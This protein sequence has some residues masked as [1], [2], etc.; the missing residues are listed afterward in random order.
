MVS[1]FR[2]WVEI[3][4][5][6][7]Y[8]LSWGLNIMNSIHCGF[9]VVHIWW[10]PFMGLFNDSWVL[11]FVWVGINSRIIIRDEWWLAVEL[12]KHV[13]FYSGLVSWMY[14]RPRVY[15]R[16]R[17]RTWYCVIHLATCAVGWNLNVFYYSSLLIVLLT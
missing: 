6:N 2:E 16:C 13:S 1:Q 5:V 14:L 17:T 12:R 8:S 7:H 9:I 4:H 15:I 3:H 11:M 10:F